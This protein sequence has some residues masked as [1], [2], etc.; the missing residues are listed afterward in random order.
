MECLVLCLKNIIAQL[1]FTYICTKNVTSTNILVETLNTYNRVMLLCN[2]KLS[3]T[4]T[5]LTKI[6][7]VLLFW[8]KTKP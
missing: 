4:E 3:L 5:L 8:N 2:E 1:F 7:Y 6:Y